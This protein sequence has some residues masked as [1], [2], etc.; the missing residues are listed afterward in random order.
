[1]SPLLRR[2]WHDF[3]L[4]LLGIWLV[5]S[6]WLLA[7]PQVSDIVRWN[8]LVG[9]AAIAVVAAFDLQWPTVWD[10]WILWAVG[11]WLAF[12]PFVLG[13]TEGRTVSANMVI[14][15]LLTVIIATAAGNARRRSG[16]NRR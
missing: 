13:F 12:A 2:R 3:L 14:T 10:E 15:G 6:P 1:M 8:A 5:L 11:L 16:S 4:I 7:D 9:G